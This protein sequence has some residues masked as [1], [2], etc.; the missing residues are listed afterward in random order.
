MTRE[1][2]NSQYAATTPGGQ[3]AALVGYA[4]KGPF[5]PV[6]VSGQQDFDQTFG[7]TLEDMP[8]LAQAAA[9]YFAQADTLLV[10]RAGDDRDPD[11]YP[12]AAQYASKNVRLGEKSV[13]ATK[14]L[15]TFTRSRM[16]PGGSYASA[17]AYSVSVLA[18]HRAF[19]SPMHLEKWSATLHEK[20]N[21]VGVENPSGEILHA[22]VKI[23]S[24][25]S[26]SS[27]FH[28]N[29]KYYQNTTGV[30]VERA[31]TGTRTGTS[32]GDTIE[33]S[34][35]NYSYNGT[36]EDKDSDYITF[37][38]R[39][40][41]AVIGNQN[42][43]TGKAWASDGSDDLELDFNNELYTVTFDADTTSAEE[44]VA[45]VNEKLA[46]A[47]D[48]NGQDYDLTRHFEAFFMKTNQ[49]P[50][51]L[52]GLR[53][54][55]GDTSSASGFT[56]NSSDAA[57]LFGWSPKTY[58]DTSS[59]FGTYVAQEEFDGNTMTFTGEVLFSKE[60]SEQGVLSFE[61]PIDVEITAP[62]SGNWTLEDIKDQLNAGLQ[63]GH[64]GYSNNPSRATAAIDTTSGKIKL[65][66][67]QF[68]I[69]GGKAIVRLMNS[70]GNSLIDLLNGV[71]M[72]EDGQP[73]R[74]VGEALIKLQ[75]AEKG[76]YGNRLTLRVETQQV[77]TGPSTIQLYY[78]VAVLLDGKE[79]SN[80]Q[81]VNWDNPSSTNFVPRLLEEDQYL[82]IDAEDEDGNFILKK[83]PDGD[84]TLGDD[85][86]PDGVT[87]SDATIVEYTRGTNGWEEEE[88]II[89]SM[90]ADFI[91][92]LKKIYNPEVFDFNLVAAPGSA[93]SS[94]QNEIQTLC[95]SRRDCFGIIDAAPFGIGH[96]VEKS[97]NHVSEVNDMNL[98]LN[99]S[100]VGAYWPWLQ[101]Y[102]ADN[103]QYVWLPPSIYALAQMVYTD[104]ISDPWFA[105]AGLTRG[106]IT[107]LDVEYSPTRLDRD[108]LYG[109]TNVINPIVKFVN[110]GIVI[111]GQKTAQ[112]T[113]SA[114]DRINVRRLLIYAEKLIAN[115]ARGFLFEQNDSTN[116]AAFAR[117]ANAILE[118][119][120]QR[121]GL[122][123]YQVVCDATTNT[124]DLID[125]NIM[126]GQ[127]FVQPTKTIE[128]IQVDFTI[129]GSGEVEISE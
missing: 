91:H 13:S 70:G 32:F 125:Q 108:I 59:V 20:T 114:T 64:D 54:K 26:D 37:N 57:S 1:I 24:E 12:Q 53:R 49:D 81:R 107:A 78:N 34:V 33:G 77:Q 21:T 68:A 62:T 124:P 129:N 50:T 106:K 80:Y 93:S 122:Y 75:A 100:Y 4:E 99:S 88:G 86:L 7:K 69:D 9:K 117:Q 113:R 127:I 58:T 112:R 19:T 39:Y 104:A 44:L 71:D 73:E 18:D 118:P 121:R 66:T 110:E 2:D 115:M 41:S 25:Q 90:D 27:D 63:A 97:V 23:A 98:N 46:F 51:F 17:T 30:T 123:Q 3:A 36:F 28:I 79:V 52:V 92:A 43:A 38:G 109:E 5:E 60:G 29:Y 126:A 65:E 15:Q 10:I 85:T 56:I 105:T 83:L 55:P 72:T 103:K 119:I 76:S 94:V 101:D 128:F 31:G 14:G 95:E 61:D 111:W 120:R 6:L 22:M 8:Y 82:K 45:H 84:W 67:S 11:L 116:W 96:G 102:D 89:T 40:T 42:L 35:Y 87:V 47:L 16:L 74:K 48:S